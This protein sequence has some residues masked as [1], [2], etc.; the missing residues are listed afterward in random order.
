LIFFAGAGLSVQELRSWA[1]FLEQE[2]QKRP[3]R[4]KAYIVLPSSTYPDAQTR[5]EQLGKELGLQHIALTY[6][7]SFED[8]SSEMYLNQLDA[9]HRNT[10]VFY[11]H[12]IIV[13]KW[14]DVNIESMP[15]LFPAAM[16]YAPVQQVNE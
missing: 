8:R 1:L 11:D 3:G 15:Y 16:E 13:R 12:A 7:P 6:V 4:F 10:I 9:K 5:L 14:T 2:S